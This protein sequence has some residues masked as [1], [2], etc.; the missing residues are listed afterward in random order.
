MKKTSDTIYGR[1]RRF[2]LAEKKQD[3]FFIL[4]LLVLSGF[5]SLFLLPF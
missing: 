2:N 5:L 1:V 3:V 4:L